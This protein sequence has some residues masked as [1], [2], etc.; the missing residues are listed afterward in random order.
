MPTSRES[1]AISLAKR[2][3]DRLAKEELLAAPQPQRF[4]DSLANGSLKEGDWRLAL[5][6]APKRKK[7][8]TKT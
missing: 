8:P 2:I 6:S 7:R 1:P 5:E 4:T 3:A